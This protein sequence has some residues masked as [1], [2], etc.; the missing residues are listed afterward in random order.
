MDHDVSLYDGPTL[1]APIRRAAVLLHPM[2]PAA[3]ELVGVVLA[4]LQEHGV[5][6]VIGSVWGTTDIR[7]TLPTVDV[8][9]VLGGDGSLL[10]AARLAA[11]N[12]VPIVGIN[13]GRLG[14]LAEVEPSE[15]QERLVRIIAGHYWIEERI[16]LVAELIRGD[17][18][19]SS[20]E[21]L[22]EVVLARRHL[23]RVVRV[24]ACIDGHHLTTY[25][26]DGVL[27]ATP[28][29]SSAYSLAAGGPVL[30]PEVRNLV[31]TPISPHL[32][33]RSPLV[34][35]ETTEVRLTVHTDHEASASFDG[36][37]DVELRSGDA[38][39]VR[40]APY[41]ALFLRAQ[42]RNYFYHTLVHKL[43]INH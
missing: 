21:C 7:A 28:T 26:A 34:L 16:M 22:N 24:D 32:S 25:T 40:V 4:V 31:L 12:A 20:F 5:E 10:R 43:G 27:V 35:P 23:S 13:L 8:C 33:L 30:H 11:S 14:F 37:S 41:R 3:Q 19:A 17:A 9:F 1:N 15:I 38:V 29:G 42:E 39:V 6:T 18:L 36:Q 2:V